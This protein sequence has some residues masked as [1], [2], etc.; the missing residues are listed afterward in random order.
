MKVKK[1][2]AGYLA[3]RREK[4]GIQMLIWVGGAAIWL[5]ISRLIMK[6]WLSPLALPA[7]LPCIPAVLALIRLLPFLSCKGISRELAEE[8]RKKA[9]LLTTAFDLVLQD[10]GRRLP[11]DALVICD[12]KIFGYAPD[13]KTDPEAAAACI[14]RTL[15]EQ[16][17]P[18]TTV[19]IF[20]E[21]VPFLS[22]AEGLNNMMEVSHSNDAKLERRLRRLILRLS[23]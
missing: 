22:R 12:Q 18:G 20:S 5:V 19:K 6:R 16:D 23:L 15:D 1:G 2:Q 11:V 13:P 21:Y 8:I 14:R 17:Y 4:F 3:A 10:D 7:L 9:S